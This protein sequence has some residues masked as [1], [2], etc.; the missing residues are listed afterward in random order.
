MIASSEPFFFSFLLF[1][2]HFFLFS[3]LAMFHWFSYEMVQNISWYVLADYTSASVESARHFAMAHELNHIALFCGC[4]INWYFEIIGQYEQICY[5]GFHLAFL[6]FFFMLQTFLHISSLH[7]SF[8][9][10]VSSKKTLNQINKR[11][12]NGIESI[13][14]TIAWV[15]FIKVCVHCSSFG[16]SRK[17]WLEWIT[18]FLPIIWKTWEFKA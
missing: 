7:F 12:F 15:R 9:K 10:I 3:K 6:R 18:S 17:N 5:L 13:M 1:P 8:L 14:Q 2:F 11:C 4:I 16:F